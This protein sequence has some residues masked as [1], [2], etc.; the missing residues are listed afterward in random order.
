[1]E[2]VSDIMEAPLITMQEVLDS[3][4]DSD[5]MAAFLI[6]AKGS[7]IEYDMD[8]IMER[9]MCQMMRFRTPSVLKIIS[10]RSTL[11]SV[12]EVSN[13]FAKSYLSGKYI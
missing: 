1:M 9:E 13:M 3:M 12:T 10:V 11:S 7:I 2:E 6:M 8:T 4:L 5:I